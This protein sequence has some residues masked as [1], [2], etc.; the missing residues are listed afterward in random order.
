MIPTLSSLV[1][2]DVIKMTTAGFPNLLCY[3]KRYILHETMHH[4]MQNPFIDVCFNVATR[5]LLVVF[6]NMACM[7]MF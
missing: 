2:M 7:K 4:T 6:T 3:M 1:A 5:P